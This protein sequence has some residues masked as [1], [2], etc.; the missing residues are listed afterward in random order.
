MLLSISTCAAE[1]RFDHAVAADPDTGDIY[2][3]GGTTTARA[4]TRPLFG[5]T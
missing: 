5:S 2:V 3:F 1:P 4:Y